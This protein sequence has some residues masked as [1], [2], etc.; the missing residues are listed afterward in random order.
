MAMQQGVAKEYVGIA[1]AE[2]P[3]V[4][5]EG[6][7]GVSYDETVEVVSPSGDLRRGR[8]LEVD[9]DRVV[10]E[11]FQGTSELSSE[12][13]RVRFLGHPLTVPVSLEM[14][15]RI[16][17]AFGNPQDGGPKPIA[18]DMRE[19]GGTPI[20]P[21]ARLYPS[22]FIQTGISAIDGMNTLVR[23]QKLPI[24]SGSGLPHNQI[25]AQIARQAE[26]P[27]AGSEFAIVFAAMGVSHDVATFF[28]TSFESSGALHNSV[29]FLSLADDPPMERIVTPRTALTMA[30]YLAFDHG[31]HVLVILTNMTDYA[32]AIREVASVRG[33]V[34]GRKGYPGYMYSDLASLYE[35]TGRI[36]GSPGSIT[37]LPILTMPNDDITDPVPDLT[38]FITEGQIVLSRDLYQRGIYPPID[39]LP[40]LS[41]LMKDGIGEGKTRS[42]HPG[43][44]SQLYAAYAHVRDVRSLA[45]IIGAEELSEAD[46]A[47]LTFGDEFER[48]FV[49]QGIN[50]DRTIEDTLEIG[51]DVLSILPESELQRVSREELEKHYRAGRF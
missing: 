14:M 7:E 41:R 4:F 32:G 51:W 33:E 17:D 13:T 49:G 50:Q 11:V 45:A 26:I 6:A 19:V 34:P 28:R 38:G 22:E 31:R 15:G 27:G 8:V 10:I 18:D 43:L 48:R 36:E 42:D 20:N 5:V 23:G 3:L 12:A 16:F 2:G 35:R 25:A 47:Y 30:E 40:S 44:A 29:L 39:V 1:G 46:K 37:Q 21:T 9:R 24:F